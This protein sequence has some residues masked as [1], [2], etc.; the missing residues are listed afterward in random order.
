MQFAASIGPDQDVHLCSLI[1][2]FSVHWH[3]LQYPLCK[4]TM[5][6]QISLRLYAG[7]SGPA[8]SANNTRAL[9]VHCASYTFSGGNPVRLLFFFF[10]CF[11]SENQS[12]LKEKNFCFLVYASFQKG[13]GYAGKW[14]GIK[15]QKLS[16]STM[17][18]QSPLDLLKLG[19]MFKERIC[20][21]LGLLLKVA[22]GV[23]FDI[24]KITGTLSN[25]FSQ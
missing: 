19:T 25:W 22:K 16:P 11:S 6:A 12:I 24:T 14:T 9:L 2:E 3:I 20:F 5:K 10:F 4:W 7:W 21:I 23:N 17:C 8:L 18:I 15:S 1:W 13:L